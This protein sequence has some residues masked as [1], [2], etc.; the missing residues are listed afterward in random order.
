[1][2]NE[3]SRWAMT[4]AEMK[5][6]LKRIQWTLE[7]ESCRECDI[8]IEAVGENFDL[9][10]EIFK[11]LDEIANPDAII[12]S[13]TST[14][15]VTK[16]AE[17]TERKDKILGMHFLHPVPKIP[18]VELIRAFDTSDDTIERA[19]AFAAKIGKTHVEVYEYP[20]FVTTRVIVPT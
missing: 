9:K 11:K 2:E 19:K 20:G 6:I 15:S 12:I 5:S 18:L 10:R 13:N 14:L 7:Y 3:I 4:E 16:I 1:M 8:I 17:V